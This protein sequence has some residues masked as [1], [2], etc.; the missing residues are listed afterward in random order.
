MPSAACALAPQASEPVSKRE[1]PFVPIEMRGRGRRG[2]ALL[3]AEAAKS[4]VRL[5]GDEAPRVR[6]KHRLTVQGGRLW[7]LLV[8]SRHRRADAAVKRYLAAEEEQGEDVRGA[9]SAASK[10]LPQPAKPHPGVQ[11]QRFK[12]ELRES[13]KRLKSQLR[14][15]TERARPPPAERDDADAGQLSEASTSAAM[16][17]E[18][19]G[20]ASPDWP[21]SPLD[22]ICESVWDAVTSKAHGC[23]DGS[24]AEGAPTS[25]VK[26]RRKG[27]PARSGCVAIDCEMVGVGRCRSR[28]MLAR[29]AVVDEDGTC[30][31]DNYVRPTETVTDYRT[32]WSGIRARNLVGAPTFDSVRQRVAQL[33]RG[34][35]LVGHAIHN[36]LKV[37][38]ITHPP[39]LI[40]DTAFFPGLR[41]A[42]SAVSDTYDA[43]QC[44]SLKNLCK[45]V[46]KTYIQAGEHCPVEDAVSTM[47]LYMRFRSDWEAGLLFSD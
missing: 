34:K 3:G 11:A 39:A 24:T 4:A 15:D 35:I 25:A 21:A 45:Y 31:L 26:P 9:H 44:P 43:S 41:R 22:E 33:I 46:L 14:E 18:A 19:P 12:A 13:L 2:D 28:S 47:Q 5:V 16:E 10:R 7:M 27:A 1:S 29:V 40:R 23:D 32:R 17:A 37:L 30:L 38:N 6:R 20:S 42:L 36:D 8:K